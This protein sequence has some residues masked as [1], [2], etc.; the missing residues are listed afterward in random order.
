MNKQF[1]ITEIQRTA[2]AN[3]G[4]PL[5]QRK[6]ELET[7]VRPYDW[8]AYWA[9]WSDAVSEAGLDPN[10]KSEAYSD[11]YLLTQLIPLVREFGRLPTNREMRLKSLQGNDL[12]HETTYRRFGSKLHLIN[13]MFEFCGSRKDCEDVV[14]ICSELLQT[15]PMTRNETRV[16]S[17]ET[18]ADLGYVY[19]LKSGKFYKIGRS[20]STGRREYELAIQLPEKATINHKITTDDPAGIEAYWHNRFADKRK[21]GEWFDLSAVEVK[22]FKRRKFM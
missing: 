19:L 2:K 9:R 14:M 20:N 5:G 15:K 12:P 8:Q 16:E 22:V 3:E 21:N 18:E 17:A 7:G 13:R 1:I 11:E 6:F 10:V 4:A